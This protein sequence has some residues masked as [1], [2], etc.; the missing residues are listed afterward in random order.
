MGIIEIITWAAEDDIC[1]IK[2][3][4]LSKGYH[5]FQVLGISVYQYFDTTWIG[6]VAM[7]PSVYSLSQ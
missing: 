1:P 5:H 3:K 6:I 2:I 4:P 7:L